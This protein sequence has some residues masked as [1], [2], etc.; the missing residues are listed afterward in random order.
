MIINP[1]PQYGYDFDI[2]LLSSNIDKI[3]YLDYASWN[4][5]W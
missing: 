3:N 1:K 4:V 5:F 2:I